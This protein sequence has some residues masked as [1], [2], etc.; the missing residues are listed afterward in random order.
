MPVVGVT[1]IRH[2]EVGALADSLA[3]AGVQLL[4]RRVGE[5]QL[6]LGVPL[7]LHGLPGGVY[8]TLQIFT[9]AEGAVLET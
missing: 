8:A 9:V 5:A 2:E 3:Y 4:R 1:G 6:K 7:D